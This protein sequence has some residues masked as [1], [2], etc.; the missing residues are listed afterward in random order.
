MTCT[1]RYFCFLI[2]I[3]ALLCALAGPVYA[4]D[5]ESEVTVVYASKTGKW[6]DPKLENLH[7]RLAGLFDFTLYRLEANH[8]K[9]S[10]YKQPVDMT[11]PGGRALKLTPL[12]KDSEQRIKVQLSIPGLIETD[13]R[14]KDGG[15]IILGGPRHEKGVLIL[16]IRMRQL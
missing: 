14:L 10:T 5:I 1:T 8:K 7:E 2:A 6:V 3:T 13:F 4:G 9:A 16:I 12:E 11:L 15:T